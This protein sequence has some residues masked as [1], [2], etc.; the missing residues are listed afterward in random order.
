MG[1][2]RAGGPVFLNDGYAETSM[3]FNEWGGGRN[4][5]TSPSGQTKYNVG[6]VYESDVL[7]AMQQWIGDTVSALSGTAFGTNIAGRGCCGFHG[8][9]ASS[10]KNSEK[11]KFG[12]ATS[13][14]R[15]WVKLKNT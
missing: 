10:T 4:S 14:A 9:L 7:V 11:L 13:H 1:G 2:T 5:V 8:S 12:R 15:Q 6:Q 3:S